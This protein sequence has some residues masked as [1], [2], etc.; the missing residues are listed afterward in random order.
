M[1]DWA[2]EVRSRLSTVRLSPTREAEIVEELSQHLDDR[3]RE[4]VAGGADPDAAARLALAEFR[5]TDVLAQY[6]A[7]LR[8]AQ[9]VDPVPPVARGSLLGG[10]GGDLRDALRALGASP[11]FTISALVVLM[12]A[13]GATTA[14]FS[15]V[16]A[17]VLRGLPF[18]ESDR[19]VAL[20]E[21]EIPAKA[22]KAAR[23]VPGPPDV[24]WRDPQALL[25]IQPQNYLDWA[26]QQQVFESIAAIADLAEFTLRVPGAEPEDLVAQRVTAGFFDVLR[27]RP[28][29]GRAFT[30]ENEVDGRHRVAIL[31]D[32]FIGRFMKLMRVDPGF[33]PERV[34]TTQ[35]FRRTLPGQPPADWGPALAEIVERVSQTRGVVHA[36]AVSPGIPLSIR[37]RINGLAIRGRPIE[38]DAGVSIKVVT[39]EYHK[40]L[41]IP[42]RSGRLFDATDRTGTADVVIMSESAAR[43]FFPGED[44]VDRVVVLDGIDRTVIGVVADVRQWSLETPARSEV[45]VPMAQSQSGTGYLVIRTSVD[46]NDVLPAVKVA[47]LSV[48]PDV[49]LRFVTTM[50]DVIRRQTAPRRLNMLMLGLFGLL[51]LVIAAVGIFGLMVYVVSQ[52][53]REIGVRMALGATRSTIVRMVV[54]NACVL[55]AMGL[56]IGG[57]GAWYLGTTAKRFLFELQAHDPRAFV[58]AA[59]AL[60]V[61]ALVASVIPARRAATVDPVTAL[62]TE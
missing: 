57:A 59:V 31:S 10:V 4:L 36:A 52:R 39:P 42:L 54:A 7:P 1:P 22:G 44:P 29:L 51:G 24:D 55:V 49:P 32:A 14:I 61:A 46:P 2:P 3:W 15:V 41:R 19:I 40:A 43:T 50:E 58:A 12:L 62:R 26:A 11:G 6:L 18:D 37:M 16:D 56:L 28:A 60:S 30:A 47:A 35:I 25:R 21:R 13:I 5:G 23:A 33:N 17:V 45:Y 27:I 34:L 38:G 8:Q 9:W 53:T 48:L 20:G